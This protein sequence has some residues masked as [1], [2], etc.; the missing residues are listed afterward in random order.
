MG[1]AHGKI[2]NLRNL[3][4]RYEK[5]AIAA[6]RLAGA[7]VKATRRVKAEKKAKE[8]ATAARRVVRNAVDAIAVE[9]LI[10]RGVIDAFSEP[11]GEADPVITEA[12]RVAFTRL[13][14]SRLSVLSGI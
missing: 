4:E 8:I 1:A 14:R 2:T 9:D 10:I 7:R 3:A 5:R 13:P 11:A 6:E 12:A